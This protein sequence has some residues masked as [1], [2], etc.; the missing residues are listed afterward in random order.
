MTPVEHFGPTAE[1]R[2]AVSGTVGSIN[3]R[4]AQLAGASE[5][6]EAP[7]PRRRGRLPKH[8]DARAQPRSVHTR[9]LPRQRG[10]GGPRKNRDSGLVP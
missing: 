9:A 10:R 6:S 4:V 8:P 3:A 5:A 1:I 7:H 2:R